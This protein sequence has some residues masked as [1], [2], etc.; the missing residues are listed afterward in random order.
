MSGALGVLAVLGVAVVL[1]LYACIAVNAQSDDRDDD[2][3]CQ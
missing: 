2:P 3:P 1:I